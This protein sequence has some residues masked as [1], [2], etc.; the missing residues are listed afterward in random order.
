MRIVLHLNLLV[1]WVCALAVQALAGP[2]AEIR[3][4]HVAPKGDQETI[5]VRLST[6]VMPAIIIATNPDRLVLQFPNRLP[7]SIRTA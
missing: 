6:S 1:L 4:V 7:W 3:E 5:D 2:A